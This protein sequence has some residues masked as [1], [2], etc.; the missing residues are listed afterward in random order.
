VPHL[1]GAEPV[2]QLDTEGRLPALVQG[3]RQGLAGAGGEPQRRQ[4]LGAGGGMVVVAASNGE[5]RRAIANNA[6]R[7]NDRPVTDPQA[8][9]GPADLTGDEV[10]KL[11]FGRKKQ[12]LLNPS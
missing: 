3:G 8:T 2:E 12:A 10:I 9:L 7:V 6:I 4:V 1:G 11:S 5:V